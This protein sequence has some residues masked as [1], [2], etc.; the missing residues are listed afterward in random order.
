MV[1]DRQYA[2]DNTIN[3]SV[4]GTDERYCWISESTLICSDNLFQN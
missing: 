1:P 4:L 2:F 3:Y